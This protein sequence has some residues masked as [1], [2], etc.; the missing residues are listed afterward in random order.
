[1]H[2]TEEIEFMDDSVTCKSAGNYLM[3]RA[4]MSSDTCADAKASLHDTCCYSL[5]DMCGE[6]SLDWDVFINFEGEDINC[7]DLNEH[8]RDEKVVNGEEQ[9]EAIKVDY[10]DTC[11]YESPTTACLLCKQDG[12]FFDLNEN[13]QVDFNGPTTCKEV[14]NFMIR[15][16][17]DTDPVC[18]VTQTSLF[19]ECCYEM[20]SLSEEEG[21]F[22]DY[23]AEVEMDGNIATCLELADAIKE[24][25]ISKDSPDCQSLQEA[26]S[27]I[28]SY[29]IPENA[30]DICPGNA[31]SISL[32]SEW[33][34]KEMLCI[35][36]KSRISSREEADSEVC[37]TAQETL[38]DCCIDQ[39]MICDEPV[40]TDAVF[41]VY[42]DGVTKQ[43]KELD[44]HFYEKSIL[45]S[46]EECSTTKEKYS[47]CCY[48][49]PE[50]PCNLC[51][52]GEME[53]YD[54]MGTNS[55]DFKGQKSLC[56]DVSDEMFRREEEM[57]E[58][59]FDVKTELFEA[60]CDTKCSLCS[61][62]GLEAGVKVS[63]EGRMMTCLEVDMGLGPIGS[64]ECNA[65]VDQ[66]SGECCFEKPESPC[67]ICPGDDV[68][69]NKEVEVDYLGTKTTCESLSNYLGSR[70]EQEGEVCKMASSDHTDDC[71]FNLCSLC[72]DG[73]AD[74]DT[75]VT[76]EDKSISCGDFEW[77]LRGKSVADGTE[78]CNAV[79]NDFF[80]KVCH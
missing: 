6:Y 58:T 37:Q 5:C 44:T 42:H 80:D 53:Y 22:P 43:C 27:P 23:A 35:D 39:C 61:G 4:E 67:R 78:S 2:L 7:G 25:A 46:S 55:V 33:N 68:G 20:C 65:A 17:D 56:S 48:M 3:E 51:R 38:Q 77:I 10:F 40:K 26:F 24:A 13:V 49:E 59:C 70:E 54:L 69:V 30:C 9:C 18:A 31:V 29:S 47:D 79:Q 45:A 41:T 14:A 19:D 71:C 60:C 75:F 74:W 66:F 15:R 76:Y 72:G 16:V 73:K 64:V 62:K 11:C 52:R 21:T 34:G 12:L 36:I 8:F 50:L 57:G 28:C 63:H 32:S 1:M